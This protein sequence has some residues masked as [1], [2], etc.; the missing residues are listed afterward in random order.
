MLFLSVYSSML[1]NA[2]V[3]FPAGHWY[4]QGFQGICQGLT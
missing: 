2:L 3:L 1:T 4:H